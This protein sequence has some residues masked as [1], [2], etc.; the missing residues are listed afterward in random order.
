MTIQFVFGV[1]AVFAGLFLLA[2]LF[3]GFWKLIITKLEVFG[4]FLGFSFVQSLTIAILG[5]ST[6]AVLGGSSIAEVGVPRSHKLEF[7]DRTTLLFHDRTYFLTFVFV[8]F[9]LYFRYNV[10]FC[11]NKDDRIR[12]G[13]WESYHPSPLV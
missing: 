9:L 5:S 7:G 12:P 1:S 2:A 3:G 10:F 6:I 4:D 13:V 11:C 8:L